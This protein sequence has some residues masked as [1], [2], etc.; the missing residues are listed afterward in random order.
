[1]W[2]TACCCFWLSEKLT[3]K[4]NFAVLVSFLFALHPMH[5]ESVAWVASRKDVLYTFFYFS[6]WL[7]YLYY[8]IPSRKKAFYFFSIFLFILA[9][10]SKSQAVTFPLVLLMSEWFYY[11]KWDKKY[12][13]QLIPFFVLSLA[14]GYFTLQG[15]AASADKYAAPLSFM[16]KIWYSVI[17]TGI[18]LYKAFLPVNQ[19]AIYAFPVCGIPVSSCPW[20]SLPCSFWPAF[21]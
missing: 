18:Y 19:S 13:V 20:R 6:A 15:A 10:L 2:L 17:A 1:M 8:F 21:G 5:V 11:R 14:I 16:D 12:L 9:L 4:L 3:G 7:S